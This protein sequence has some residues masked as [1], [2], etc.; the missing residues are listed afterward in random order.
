MQAKSLR[1][2]NGSQVS[3]EFQGKELGDPAFDWGLP[4]GVMV[5]R[6]PAVR[7]GHGVS[8]VHPGSAEE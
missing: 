3:N 5:D 4:S 2:V 6:G 1:L 7:L 8:S